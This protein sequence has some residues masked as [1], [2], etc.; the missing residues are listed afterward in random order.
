MEENGIFKIIAKIHEMKDGQITGLECPLGSGRFFDYRLLEKI[1]QP[2]DLGSIE[3]PRSELEIE[4]PMQVEGYRVSGTDKGKVM[5]KTVT[6]SIYENVFNDVK[7]HVEENDM[8]INN[9]IVKSIIKNYWPN[10]KRKSVNSYATIYRAF[11]RKTL[12]MPV[13]KCTGIEKGV[14]LGMVKHTPI[15]AGV[16]H[17]IE[18]GM[19]SGE[20]YIDL[21]KRVEKYYPGCTESTYRT[22]VNHYKRWIKGNNEKQ[23]PIKQE[24]KAY[25]NRDGIDR[26]KLV[27]K[28]G[29]ICIYEK[30]LDAYKEATTKTNAADEILDV[31]RRFHPNAK[32]ISITVYNSAYRRYTG[33]NAPIKEIKEKKKRGKYKKRRPKDCIGYS[34]KYGTWI[35][36]EEYTLVKRAL[37]KYGFTAT[38]DA[39]EAE[40]GLRKHRVMPVLDYMIGKRTVYIKLGGSGKRIYRPAI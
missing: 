8:H 2:E 9:A 25:S 7:R 11:V 12:N 40:T 15:F 39:I 21:M 23:K 30:V 38:S 20:K 1:K 37:Y 14:K 17:D 32:D 35:R 31:L 29:S 6:I 3:I 24:R 36:N 27:T 4:E 26:G 19:S 13:N 33:Y 5:A 16:I 34:K 18:K 22:Y 28:I 10:I